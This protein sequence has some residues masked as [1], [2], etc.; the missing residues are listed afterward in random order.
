M[1]HQFNNGKL[2]KDNILDPSFINLIDKYPLIIADPPYGDIVKEKWDN[3]GYKEY[4]ELAK[5]IEK[6]LTKGGSA[7]VWG[8]IGKYKNRT[9][10][11]FLANVEE[12]TNLH[13]RNVITWN[14]KRAYGK[15]DDYLFTREEVAWLVNGDNPEIFNIP[16]LD[17]KRGYA[18]YNAKYPAKSEYKRRTN[19]WTDITEVFSGKKHKCEKPEK[20]AE[21]M[22]NTHTNPGD[23]VLD[24]F[25]G[26]GNTS[27]VASRLGRRFVA[28]E[29]DE[30]VCK[31]L[32]ERLNE[33][34]QA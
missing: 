27:V 13:L 10:F 2:I 18:G 14:K 12:E 28:V 33:T 20:L 3:W 21:V 8:G 23:E 24:L 26:S 34:L 1:I 6:A 11:K 19:V 22:I 30:M 9:F 16:L 32:L 25:A 15:S 4:I 17:E 7:Y 29:N 31:L 5:V